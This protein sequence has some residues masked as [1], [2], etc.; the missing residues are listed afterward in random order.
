MKLQHSAGFTLLET[1]VSFLIL[2]VGLLGI[3]ALQGNALRF[4][5]QAYLRSQAVIVAYDIFERMR[6][7][8]AGVSGGYYA[9]GEI[10]EHPAGTIDCTSIACTPRQLALFDMTKWNQRILQA[11]PSGSGSV[12]ATGEGEY[13]VTIYWMDRQNAPG[14]GEDAQDASDH[15]LIIS[16]TM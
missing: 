10:V 2:G 3:A 16:A 7:N 1:V 8:P 6:A 4:S 12:S 13:T 14:D 15:S 11:L 5:S 9:P